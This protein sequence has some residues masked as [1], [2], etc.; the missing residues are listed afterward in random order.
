MSLKKTARSKGRETLE[1]NG[2]IWRAW[3]MAN[4]KMYTRSTGTGERREAE[5]KQASMQWGSIDLVRG[6]IFVRRTRNT[7]ASVKLPMRRELAR[8]LEETPSESRKGCL[9]PEIA[10]T[11]QFNSSLLS[12]RIQ[13]GFQDADIQTQDKTPGKRAKA[14]LGFHCLRHTLVSKVGNAGVPLAVVQSLV[15][16]GNLMMSNAHYHLDDAAAKQAI[17]ATPS[18]YLALANTEAPSA[19]PEPSGA[20]APKAPL[21]RRPKALWS[22]Y[23][24]F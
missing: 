3:R 6:Y 11:H 17:N 8:L 4:G 15:G 22:S 21:R 1:K 14:P 23:R 13:K 20:V 7:G 5:K 16:H 10:M 19:H 2:N 9:L 12:S 18:L 24:Q